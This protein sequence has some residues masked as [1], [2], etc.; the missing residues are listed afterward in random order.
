MSSTTSTTSPAGETKVQIN[1]AKMTVDETKAHSTSANIPTNQRTPSTWAGSNEL[2]DAIDQYITEN[3]E[4]YK[5]AQAYGEF[6]LSSRFAN[7]DTMKVDTTDIEGNE[8][9]ADKTIKSMAYYGLV[10]EDLDSYE[11]AALEYK[12]GSD[13]KNV[14]G[15]L[16]A[17]MQA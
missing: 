9:M 2:Q 12:F 5:E 6:I 13:W 14:V 7:V 16:V 4:K 1:E 10:I 15:Q 8:I 3:P 11:I 17:E